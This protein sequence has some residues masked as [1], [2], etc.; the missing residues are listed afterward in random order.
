MKN[1]SIGASLLLGPLEHPCCWITPK[2]HVFDAG[3]S[4]AGGEADARAEGLPP[5]AW[6][7]RRTFTGGEACA[8]SGGGPPGARLR[9]RSD[10]AL[11]GPFAAGL[12][13]ARSSAAAAHGGSGGGGGGAAPAGAKGVSGGGGGGGCP[14]P[15]GGGGGGCCGPCTSAGGGPRGGDRVRS[16]MPPESNART[17]AR[18]GS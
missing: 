7:L 8:G 2:R 11:G 12:L 3:T 9:R 14:G 18:L 5:R 4:F 13:N 1:G 16:D 6:L 10:R 15:G 17:V